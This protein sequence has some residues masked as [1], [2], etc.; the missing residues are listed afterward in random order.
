MAM[1]IRLVCKS[2]GTA[3]EAWDEGNPYYLD[4]QG[5]KQYAYH[6]S[7]LRDQCIGNDA[8]HLC[9]ACGEQFMVDSQSPTSRCPK[10]ESD[11]IADTYL[12]DGRKCP[13][14]KVGRFANTGLGS[15]S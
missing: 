6:P 9:L 12:L 8:P 7:P 4:E 5:E 14:C 15:I 1:S 2:C 3:I 10:C 13:C 11:D